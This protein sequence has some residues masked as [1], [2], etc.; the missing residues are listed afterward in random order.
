MT[1][2]GSIRLSGAALLLPRFAVQRLHDC[3]YVVLRFNRQ[4]TEGRHQPGL[5]SVR[6]GLWSLTAVNGKD[7]FLGDV[8]SSREPLQG[9]LLNVLHALVQNVPNCPIAD[10]PSGKPRYVISA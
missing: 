1:F 5:A 8:Q 6:P 4:L 9:L 7:L 2:G 10:P 3:H